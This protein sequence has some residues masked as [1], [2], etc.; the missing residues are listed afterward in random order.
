MYA[1][2]LTPSTIEKVHARERQEYDKRKTIT[3]YANY[4]NILVLAQAGENSC[5]HVLDGTRPEYSNGEWDLIR[6]VGPYSELEHVLTEETPHTPPTVAFGPEPDRGWCYYYQ[7]ADLARQRGAWDQ[8]LVIGGQAFGQGLE[9]RDLIEW[10]PFLQ[11][12]AVSGDA[13]RLA[14]LAPVIGAD[15]YIAGQACQILGA[16]PSL[17]SPVKE[18]VTAYYCVGQ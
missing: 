17:S 4:R 16:M 9:P 6:E 3:T 11:A 8:V 12:Y 10:M 15:P 1:A 7:K 18:V 2:L 5:V 14:E 13:A